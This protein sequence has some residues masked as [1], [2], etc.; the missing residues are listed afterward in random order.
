[1]KNPEKKRTLK[2]G[3]HPSDIRVISSD[4]ENR[5][6]K[7]TKQENGHGQQHEEKKI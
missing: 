1:M 4:M 6:Q 3:A 7:W 2:K 5:Q